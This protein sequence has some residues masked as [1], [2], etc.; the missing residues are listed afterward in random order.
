[1]GDWG[2]R[3]YEKLVETSTKFFFEY[4]PS[5]PPFEMVEDATKQAQVQPSSKLTFGQLITSLEASHFNFQVLSCCLNVFC[6]S[7][8][9]NP[10]GIH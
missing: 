4:L 6:W 3:F 7:G 1:M 10:I 9:L 8:C 5:S 2:L